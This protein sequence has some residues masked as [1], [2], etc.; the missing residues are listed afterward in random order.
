[1]NIVFLFWLLF[2]TSIIGY[3]FNNTLNRPTNSRIRVNSNFQ[4][5]KKKFPES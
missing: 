1:M 3:I 2:F 4:G 5:N